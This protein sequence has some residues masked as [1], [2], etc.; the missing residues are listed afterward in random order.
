M[1]AEPDPHPV[2]VGLRE[3]GHERR[4]ATD[5]RNGR[6][7]GWDRRRGERRKQQLRTLLFAAAALATPS[8]IM[9]LQPLQQ[10]HPQVSISIDQFTPV[11]PE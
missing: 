9:K 11:R 2:P 3:P 10:L 8:Q 1:S 6:R 5:R 4:H 7:K